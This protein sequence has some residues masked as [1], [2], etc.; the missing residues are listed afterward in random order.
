MYKTKEITKYN[1]NWQ[2]TRIKNKQTKDLNTKLNNIINFYNNNKNYPTWERIYNYLEGLY[3]GYKDL[4]SKVKI[5]HCMKY[6]E[7]Y[8]VNVM[9]DSDILFENVDIKDLKFLYLDLYKRNQKWL[10]SNYRNKDLNDFLI[11]LYEQINDNL[12]PK[13]FDIYPNKKSTYKFLY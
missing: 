5:K 12:L 2:I 9:I 7:L 6:L 1:L 13:N 8:K 3:L 4:E 11:I 10:K